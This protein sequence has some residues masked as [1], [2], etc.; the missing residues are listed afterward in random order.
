MF[1]VSEGESVNELVQLERKLSEIVFQNRIAQKKFMYP[2]KH[3]ISPTSSYCSR[4]ASFR[5]L[6]KEP[7]DLE[8]NVSGLSRYASIGNAI[9]SHMFES[10]GD[11]VLGTDIPVHNGEYYKGR[12]PSADVE[13][14]SV[15]KLGFQVNGYIDGIL[16]IDGTYVVLD[17]KSD[18]VLERMHFF[19]LTDEEWETFI[20]N[21]EL[22]VKYEEDRNFVTKADSGVVNYHKTQVL[23][24]CAMTGID[25]ACLAYGSRLVKETM[26]DEPTERYE[27]FNV[28][29]KE[30][31]ELLLRLRIAYKLTDRGLLVPKPSNMKTQKACGFCDWK[32]YCW[33]N[34]PLNRNA[35]KPFKDA[36]KDDIAALMKSEK[37]LVEEFLS[38][39]NKRLRREFF[40]NPANLE[41]DRR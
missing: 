12:Y 25:V 6:L 26:T 36:T 38:E 41:F 4:L 9:E 22:T 15:D 19:Y 20:E 24:Y 14:N 10:F 7:V 27:F 29:H 8:E 40:T 33:H 18:S 32:P 21:G 16:N 5:R 17:S 39:A 13:V 2:A 35:Y 34:Q 31:V 1:G 28:E 11:A 37:P 23:I 30:L 3:H